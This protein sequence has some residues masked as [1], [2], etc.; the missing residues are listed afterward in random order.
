MV[1]KWEE[2]RAK[3]LGACV[4]AYGKFRPP[5][6]SGMQWRLV[7]TCDSSCWDRWLLNLLGQIRR[8]Q[9]SKCRL[10][11]PKNF[12][13]YERSLFQV[14]IGVVEDHELQLVGVATI[15]AAMISLVFD[16]VIFTPPNGHLYLIQWSP[17]GSAN[18]IT[19]AMISLVFDT[20]IFTQPSGHLYLIQW[21]PSGSASTITAEMISLVFDTVIFTPPNGHLYLIQWSPSGSASTITAAI[22]S[23]VFDTVIFTQPSGHLYLIQWP[24]SGSASTITA[25]MI[26]LAFDA[27]IFTATDTAD[28]RQV[29]RAALQTT[30]DAEV[31]EVLGV[32]RQEMPS[33]MLFLPKCLAAPGLS[34]VPPQTLSGLFQLLS[35]HPRECSTTRGSS[36][37]ISHSNES[38]SAGSGTSLYFHFFFYSV[39]VFNQ[40]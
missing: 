2:E 17:S 6:I 22:V 4:I 10:P 21:S 15:T 39:L 3:L 1:E 29:M 30:G 25:A 19:A 23:L 28:L 37:L 13:W 26:S 33:P 31:L 18:T 34:P 32:G 9:Q 24:P 7:T 8:W 14:F 11:H 35:V 38:T 36:G 16:T 40:F 27:A 20:V 5:G 12:E